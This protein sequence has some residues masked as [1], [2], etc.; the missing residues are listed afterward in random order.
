MVSRTEKQFSEHKSSPCAERCELLSD[1]KCSRTRVKLSFIS[2]RLAVHLYRNSVMM[3][4]GHPKQVL[5]T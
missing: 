2:H 4:V 1:V 3:D 5:Q